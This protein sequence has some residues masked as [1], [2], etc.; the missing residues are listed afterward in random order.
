MMGFMSSASPR[1]LACGRHDAPAA[2]RSSMSLSPPAHAARLLRRRSAAASPCCDTRRGCG[3]RAALMDTSFP[4]VPGAGLAEAPS[5]L[6]ALGAALVAV[7]AVAGGRFAAYSQVQFA[8]AGMLA[9]CLPKGNKTILMI[10]G[11]TKDL[12]YLPRDVLQAT[13]VDPKADESFWQ[14]AALQARTPVAVRK[15][16]Y[17]DLR[18]APDA[19]IDGAVILAPFSSMRDPLQCCREALRA[20]RPN[21]PLV[22]IQRQCGGASLQGLLGGLDGATASQLDAV[23]DLPGIAGVT[24]EV[25]AKSLDPHAVGVIMRGEVGP[26]GEGREASVES[27]V[28]ASGKGVKGPKSR[29]FN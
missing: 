26:D 13:L 2:A 19:S 7:G 22:I 14:Q 15:R 21:A 28:R 27:Q 16:P 8:R 29:G 6:I 4:A 18:F 10:G 20:L 1:A 24:W 17:E 23:S 3:T 9:N 5:S 25:A 11:G 12:Y